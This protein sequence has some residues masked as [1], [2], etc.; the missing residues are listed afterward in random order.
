MTGNGFS[1][2]HYSGDE[3]MSVIN[4]AQTMY[5]NKKHWNHLVDAAMNSKLDWENS[6]KQYIDV[7]KK[8]VDE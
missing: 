7:F 3:M 1:F 8:L 5:A 4:Y 6:A 2:A